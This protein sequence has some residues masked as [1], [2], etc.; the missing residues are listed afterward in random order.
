MEDNI[1]TGIK[2]T[3]WSGV[4]NGNIWLRTRAFVNAVIDI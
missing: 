3:V 2:A 1:K 4:L